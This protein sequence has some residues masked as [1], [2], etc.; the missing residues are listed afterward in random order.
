MNPYPGLRPFR[1]GE[2]GQYRGREALLE[3]VVTTVRIAPL[4][5]F[6]ARSGLG[7]SSFLIC[8][9]RPELG[10]ESQTAYINDWG[11][12]LPAARV[13]RELELLDRGIPPASASGEHDGLAAEAPVLILDQF[14]DVFKT[15]GDR[16]PLWELLADMVNVG[17]PKIHVIVSM[18]EEWLG[19]WAEAA[20]YLP[21]SLKSTIR[22]TPLTDDELVRAI[23]EPPRTEGSVAVDREFAQR[24][25]SEV[26]TPTAF[27]VADMPAAPGLVQLVC[28][29]MWE[30]ASTRGVPMD[31]S[32]YESLGKI[33]RIERD[34]VW[35]GLGSHGSSSVFTSV[36]RVL[37]SGIARYLSVAEDVKSVVSA[38]SIAERL[39]P[40]DFGFAAPVALGGLRRRDRRYLKK[41]P[42]T[43]GHPSPALE[44]R[45]EALL[46]KGVEAGFVR[47]QGSDARG[48]PL[49]ELVHDSLGPIFQQFGVEFDRRLRV[50]WT[51]L[52]SGIVVAL[53][54]IFTLALGLSSLSPVSLQDLELV[55]W[56]SFMSWA[57]RSPDELNVAVGLL[58]AVLAVLVMSFIAWALFKAI[59][60]VAISPVLRLMSRDMPAVSSSPPS[61]LRAAVAYAVILVG[62]I[63]VA[64]WGVPALAALVRDSADRARTAAEKGNGTIDLQSGLVA[65]V[66]FDPTRGFWPVRV[67]GNVLCNR[68]VQMAPHESRVDRLVCAALRPTVASTD[69]FTI[70][71]WI[72][73]DS[74]TRGLVAT[75]VGKHGAAYSIGFPRPRFLAFTVE[76]GLELVAYS[77][78]QPRGQWHQIVAVH[79]HAVHV[80]RLYVDG[81]K[82]EQRSLRR[83]PPNDEIDDLVLGPADAFATVFSPFM[84]A[85]GQ[86]TGS[87]A[88]LRLYDRPLNVN[89]VAYLY[90]KCRPTQTCP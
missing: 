54:C 8:K 45:L 53:A 68:G 62:V 48:R 18:R 31:W 21:D 12:G 69:Q 11:L 23:L 3:R 55:P 38:R 74:A 16:T 79:D 1:P 39:R 57:L 37:W 22:L 42:E 63:C 44:T 51:A 85:A 50:R 10:L 9:L 72:R 61:I 59:T 29:R 76:P 28:R 67:T 46:E 7:K 84:D 58:G 24:L 2:E 35:S 77:T 90:R 86:F 87:I 6:F 27:D 26:R 73:T 60:P 47:C 4:T 20:E 78:L 43:R 49:Y 56:T 64:F 83:E 88:S 75:L 34:F 52:I 32:L 80:L 14:E 5:I 17:D 71:S 81:T 36:D 25:I 66:A 30:E 82:V 13:E 15:A 65:N 70:V 19:A 89:E 40:D 33:G 41:P